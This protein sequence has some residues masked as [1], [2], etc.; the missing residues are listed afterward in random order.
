MCLA[1]GATGVR[2]NQLTAHAKPE[3]FRMPPLPP[4]E[5][6]SLLITAPPGLCADDANEFHLHYQDDSTTRYVLELTA[7]PSACEWTVSNLPE[8]L[9]EAWIQ[10]APNGRILARGTG[11][12]ATGATGVAAMQAPDLEIEGRLTRGGLAPKDLVL[13]FISP[14]SDSRFEADAPISADGSYQVRLDGQIGRYC[15]AVSASTSANLLMKCESFQPGLQ[16]FDIDVA[17][18]V[19]HITIPPVDGADTA[20][21]DGIHIRPA[22]SARNRSD[23]VLDQPQ[24]W[25]SFKL[26]DGFR[27]DYVG[28]PYGDYVVYVTVGDDPGA[29]SVRYFSVS[30]EQESVSVELSI[31]VLDKSIPVLDK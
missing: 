18:G 17:P 25:I 29:R 10:R 27:A 23:T 26:R 22:H 21:W 20:T 7:G 8:G 19:L 30:P 12:V 16:R 14:S 9:Y 1:T 15:A 31:P 2:A 24:N 11:H 5:G 6:G 28:L 3:G 13:R 4:G